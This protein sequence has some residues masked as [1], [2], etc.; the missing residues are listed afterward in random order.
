MI[1]VERAGTSE[2]ID[3]ESGVGFVG[4]IPIRN[5]WLLMLYASELFRIDGLGTVRSEETPDDLPDLVA[6]I[7][8]HAVELRQR[9]ALNTGY[10]NRS[11]P[12]S[13]VRG[14]IDSLT[15]ET[16]QLLPRGLIQCRFDELTVDTPR[17]RYVRAALEAIAGRVRRREL[18]SRCYSCAARMRVSGVAGDPPTH[19]QI[20]YERFGR[21]DAGDR[22][23]V[24]AARLAHDLGMPTEHLGDRLLPRPGRED[25]WKLF[26]CAIAGFYAVVLRERGWTVRSQRMIYWPVDDASIGLW[27]LLPAMQPDIILDHPVSGRRIMI[28]TK[29]SQIVRAGRGGKARFNSGNIYQM[30]TYL[31]SQEDCG[32][33]AA[34][35][36]E[37][38]L[39]HPAVDCDIDER[40]TIHSHRIRFATVDLAA[41]PAQIR[42]RLLSLCDP[43]SR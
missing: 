16:R 41:E 19:R 14:R 18:A 20:A 9:R 32:D 3:P 1:F 40:M 11:R 42:E 43:V 23:M 29:F 10:L 38:L 7:L 39:L 21:N 25:A 22:H 33:A 36:A 12:L 31:R 24:A 35:S 26:E 34:R 15:T 6:E 17:N 8:V 2:S 28:D 27:S 4:K 5:L 30:Y 13:R 37:G